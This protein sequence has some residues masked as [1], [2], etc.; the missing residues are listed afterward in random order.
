MPRTAAP[1][2]RLAWC[3]EQKSRLGR[4]P[5]PMHC[6]GLTHLHRSRS[7]TP[8]VSLSGLV[9]FSLIDFNKQIAALSPQSRHCWVPPPF[10]PR[11]VQARCA[12]G[13]GRAVLGDT[14]ALAPLASWEVSHRNS[15]LEELRWGGVVARLCCV[16]RCSPRTPPLHARCRG[17]APLWLTRR[18]LARSH[19]WLSCYAG[20][21]PATL[22]GSAPGCHCCCQRGS[23]RWRGG[24]RAAGVPCAPGGSHSKQGEEGGAGSPTPPPHTS[25][26]ALV[27]T[28]ACKVAPSLVLVSK[29]N[30]NRAPR[31]APP[32]TRARAHTRQMLHTPTH[33][34]SSPAVPCRRPPPETKPLGRGPAP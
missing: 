21:M 18:S 7:A 20:W 31:Q 9:R 27:A 3:K 1:R 2:A 15:R 34:P 4:H 33:V 6:A 17:R 11:A 14:R 16:P 26:P 29:T 30:T 22:I 28:G 19:A 24:R 5:H 32:P 8:S 13:L 23:R 10:A 12:C 25:S